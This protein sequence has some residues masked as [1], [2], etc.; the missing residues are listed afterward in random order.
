M[1]YIKNIKYKGQKSTST[2]SGDIRL[3]EGNGR[4]VVYN[5]NTGVEATV[6]DIN[7][8]RINDINGN[9]LTRLANDGLTTLQSDGVR[10]IR[11]GTNPFTGNVGAYITPVDVDVIDELSA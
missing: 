7:G 5:P 2:L 3:E 4:L 1:A 8:F 6:V 9:E 11:I 10:R